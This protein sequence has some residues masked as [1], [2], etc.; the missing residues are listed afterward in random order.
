MGMP[1]G[2]EGELA[3]LFMDD[4]VYQMMQQSGPVGPAAGPAMGEYGWDGRPGG[5]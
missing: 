4:G 5:Q 1:F 3:G 2:E